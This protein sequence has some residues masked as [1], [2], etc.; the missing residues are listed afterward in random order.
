MAKRSDDGMYWSDDAGVEPV[1]YASD[2][3]PIGTS[4]PNSASVETTGYAILALL[5]GGDRLTASAAARWL[6]TQR[7]SFGGYGSTQDTVVGL[8]ALSEF[9][10]S[11]RFDVDIDVTLES[12]SWSRSVSVNASN[13]DVVQIVEIPAG[14][15]LSVAA[16]GSGEVVMQVVNRFN[17]P[18]VQA[19]GEDIFTIDVTYS[20]DRIEV[21]DRIAIT[22]VATFTPP[23]PGDAGMVVIDIAIPTGFAAVADTVAALVEDTP[24]LKRYDVAGRKVILYVEDMAPNE[25]IS[26][27]FEAV[28][29]HP[30]KAQPV[31]SQVYS[32][33]TPDWRGETLGVPVEVASQ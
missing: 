18:E 3:L 20:A 14:D 22:A 19:V 9:S 31:T 6:V 28:A 5:E 30:V 27:E 12:G 32:Y 1:P 7:N 26:L 23:T 16:D 17:M 2:T 8:Q 33:Y 29:L 24:K 25:S 13:A 15:S 4:V 21:N 11:A 10:A